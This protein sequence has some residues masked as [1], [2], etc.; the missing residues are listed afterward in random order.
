MC[1]AARVQLHQKIAH[2]NRLTRADIPFNFTQFNFNL[3]MRISIKIKNS[4]CAFGAKCGGFVCVCTIVACG[5][6]L[7]LWCKSS[8]QNSDSC[9]NC[10][11]KTRIGQVGQ[12]CGKEVPKEVT[13]IIWTKKSRVCD[14]MPRCPLQNLQ[15]KRRIPGLTQFL[16]SEQSRAK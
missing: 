3:M 12:I 7:L 11:F 1:I 16:E 5:Y 15:K 10:L 4:H 8:A 2:M 14:T 6:I 9:P 13:R